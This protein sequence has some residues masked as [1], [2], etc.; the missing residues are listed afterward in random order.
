MQNR[1]T[2]IRKV[3]IYARCSTDEKRQDVENQLR[4]LRRYCESFDWPYEEV[5]EYN[6][7][8]K[9]TQAKLLHT[10]KTA[11][12]HRRTDIYG[13]LIGGAH[14]HR[15]SLDDAIL[16]KENHI[17]AAGSFQA[18]IDGIA[19]TR[20]EAS[21]VEIEVTDFNELKYALLAKPTRIML[22]NF[23]PEKVKQAVQDFGKETEFEASGNINL[24]NIRKYAETGVNYISVGWITHSAPAADLS[25]LFDFERKPS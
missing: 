9:G 6:S 18:I 15:R 10:R 22:D 3:A 14:A 13:A 25:M 24:N 17:R 7:G 16:V 11:P 1:Q 5:W 8:F 21:F 20:R 4:E 12:G 23:S 2:Q 19:K